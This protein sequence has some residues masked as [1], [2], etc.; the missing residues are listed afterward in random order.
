M[1]SF[2]HS[3]EVCAARDLK[4]Y[5]NRHFE[6]AT[7]I[8]TLLEMTD[9]EFYITGGSIRRAVLS[10]HQYG[11]LDLIVPGDGTEFV[12]L[13]QKIGLNLRFSYFGQP[14]FYWGQLQIDLVSTGDTSLTAIHDVLRSFDLQINSIAFSARTNKFIAPS[15]GLSKIFDGYA[16]INW[17]A[18]RDIEAEALAGQAIRLAKILY[19]MPRL[20]LSD[21]DRTELLTSVV[22]KLQNAEW[23]TLSSR[24]PLGRDRFIRD[25]QRLIRRRK[26]PRI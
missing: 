3:K 9:S 10:P 15:D 22:L 2:D 18:W 1:N 13:F 11:D 12:K 6:M 21:F 4:E 14:R 7:V 17:P 5:I 23:R 24:Y 26:T 20:A 16:G 8:S 19:E 25:F